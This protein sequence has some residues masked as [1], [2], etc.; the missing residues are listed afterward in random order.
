MCLSKRLVCLCI[1][2][3]SLPLDWAP[4]AFKSHSLKRPLWKLFSCG[5]MVTFPWIGDILQVTELIRMYTNETLTMAQFYFLTKSRSRF[6]AQFIKEGKKKKTYAGVRW[7]LTLAQLILGP[8][9]EGTCLVGK[10]KKKPERLR[11]CSGRSGTAVGYEHM[12][13]FKASCASGSWQLGYG[14]SSLKM[15]GDHLRNRHKT[16]FFFPNRSL[17]E[18]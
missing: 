17:F 7:F 5:F 15:T 12:S 13:P 4:W 3:I 9:Q 18:V 2:Q 14:W 16:D 10:K 8:L 11:K 1:F 6:K